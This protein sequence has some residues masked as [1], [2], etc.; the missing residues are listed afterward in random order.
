MKKTALLVLLP[1]ACA[2]AGD[3]EL[4]PQNRLEWKKKIVPAKEELAW[5]DVGWRPSFFAALRE[6]QEKD[7]PLLLWAMNGHPLG[8]T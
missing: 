7:R 6:A 4:T 5:E 3:L 2:F 8:C 1:L